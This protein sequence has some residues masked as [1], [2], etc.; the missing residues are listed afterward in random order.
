M[1]GIGLPELMYIALPMAALI[2]WIRVFRKKHQ[3]AILICSILL[4]VVDIPHFS[5]IQ[6]DNYFFALFGIG[7]FALGVFGIVYSAVAMARKSTA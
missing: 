5:L 3:M 2:A 6:T 7:C 4:V 1:I